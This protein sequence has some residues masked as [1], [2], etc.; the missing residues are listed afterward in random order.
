M[1]AM[2][3]GTAISNTATVLLTSLAVIS[4]GLPVGL[5]AA[6]TKLRPSGRHVLRHVDVLHEGRGGG[7]RDLEDHD[8]ADCAPEPMKA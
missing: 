2:R 4:S 3:T 6:G 1:S 5:S 7:H 8:V